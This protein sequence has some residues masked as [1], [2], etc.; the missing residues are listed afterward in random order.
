MRKT[1]NQLRVYPESLPIEGGYEVLLSVFSNYSLDL[2]CFFPIAC[3][4]SQV[5]PEG[6]QNDRSCPSSQR[7]LDGNCVSSVAS[8]SVFDC[9]LGYICRKGKCEDQSKCKQ[10]SD[11]TD[12]IYKENKCVDK[13]ECTKKSDC[14]AGE[15]CNNEKCAEEKRTCNSRS[16]CVDRLNYENSVCVKKSFQLESC[17]VS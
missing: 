3:S 2:H 13:P 10:N 8:T 12:Q 15:I 7:C 16:D 4:G 5:P 17:D 14:K 9:G 6:C 11:R 1:S